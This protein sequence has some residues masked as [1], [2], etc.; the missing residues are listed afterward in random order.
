[1]VERIHSVDHLKNLE[2]NKLLD[3]A[4]KPVATLITE[5][6]GDELVILNTADENAYHLNP[7]ASLIWEL[8]DA[9]RTGHEIL[10]CLLATYETG[11]TAEQVVST[12][13][14]FTDNGL[15]ERG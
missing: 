12:L 10:A 4:M 6:A 2:N 15:I 1:M 9:G 7:S 11:P 3:Q 8:V 14:G 13:R 5:S